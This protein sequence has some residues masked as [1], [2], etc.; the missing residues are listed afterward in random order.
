MVVGD[1]E[2]PLCDHGE[3]PLPASDCLSGLCAWLVLLPA[4]LSDCHLLPIPCHLHLH[5]IVLTPSGHSGT[6]RAVEQKRP[7]PRD[8]IGEGLSVTGQA[9]P[10]R[11]C[12]QGSGEAG[13]G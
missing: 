3:N 10:G 4:R 8:K 11:G 2:R 9:S 12:V 13:G 7:A 5:L 1:S 6:Y